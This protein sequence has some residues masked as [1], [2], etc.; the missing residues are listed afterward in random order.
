MN[1]ERTRERAVRERHRTDIV[2]VRDDD[3][4]VDRARKDEIVPRRSGDVDSRLR[5]FPFIWE[6]GEERGRRE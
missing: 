2:R 5:H 1:C 3:V 4:A 6:R